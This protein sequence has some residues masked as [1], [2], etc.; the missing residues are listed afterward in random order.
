MYFNIIMLIML[1]MYCRSYTCSWFFPLPGWC[2]IKFN[3]FN[4][5]ASTFKT[6]FPLVFRW[7]F[8][9]AQHCQSSPSGRPDRTSALNFSRLKGT[10]TASQPS[11]DVKKVGV[12]RAEMGWSADF[13]AVIRV[14]LK[15][16]KFR[17]LL[18]LRKNGIRFFPAKSRFFS[19]PGSLKP[20]PPQPQVR[21]GPGES[22]LGLYLR[23]HAGQGRCLGCR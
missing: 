1:I 8:H 9:P 23:L 18:K 6:T 12:P 13:E 7:F 20:Q 5:L 2:L 11:K 15:F 10:R 14:L 22:N 21:E 16:D 3:M 17:T 19:S 4:C